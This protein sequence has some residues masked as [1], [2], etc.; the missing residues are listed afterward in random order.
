MGVTYHKLI[1]STYKK[2]GADACSCHLIQED[3]LNEIVKE[4]LN[5]LIFSIIDIEK[6]ISSATVKEK[7]KNIVLLKNEQRKYEENLRAFMNL[8]TELYSDYKLEIITLSEYHEM[9]I[10]FDAKC[11]E[12]EECIKNNAK[13]IVDIQK[14][15]FPD[16]KFLERF[17]PYIQGITRLTRKMIIDFIEEVIV[18]NEKNI[19][20]RFKIED[21]LK[22]YQHIFDNK[23]Q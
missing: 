17:K 9:K 19:R 8:K 13:K 15:S 5:K 23:S 7:E 12:L 4:A 16:N 3:V 2:Y 20:I 11:K 10:G 21:E 1:C 6:R 22:K 18:D 14:E